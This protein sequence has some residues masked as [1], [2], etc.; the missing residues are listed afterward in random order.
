G[1]ASRA[2]A[3]LW[4]KAQQ[5]VLEKA[6]Q[7]LLAARDV[8]AGSTAAAEVAQQRELSVELVDAWATHLKRAVR[9]A[10]DPLQLWARL[11]HDKDAGDVH[12]QQVVAAVL[13]ET[14]ARI[15]G[16]RLDKIKAE[17]VVLDFRR[18]MP[19][20]WRT[21]GSAFGLGPAP[22][23]QAM[24]TG[25]AQRPVGGFAWYSAAR[26]DMKF[27]GLQIAPGATNDQGKLGGWQRAGETLRTPTFTVKDGA[28]YYLVR[29]AGR[30]LAVVD[31][32]RMVQGPL[33]G[34]VMMQWNADGDKLRWVRHQLQRHAGHRAHV[35]FSP[36]GDAPLEI[37][38]VAQGAEAPSTLPESLPL[39]QLQEALAPE[40][41]TS[42]AAVASGYQKILS[43]AAT[44]AGGGFADKSLAA[45]Q[46]ALAD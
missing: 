25:D 28:V 39:A 29:G 35:E 27:T 26:R 12:V 4:S 41:A 45:E 34:D 8:L 13:N 16:R 43:A 38:F 5:P 18:G 9:D 24:L 2:L 33:H 21:D 23:G 6:D 40:R 46:A 31:S 11:A 15:E 7:Y 17:D 22:I 36:V 10:D 3:P 44:A 14:Q 19:Q 30:A 42:L 20:N 32:H 37:L 1:E